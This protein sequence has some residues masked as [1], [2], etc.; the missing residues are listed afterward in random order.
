MKSAWKLVFVALCAL[1]LAQEGDDA[2]AAEAKEASKV[3]VLTAETFDDVIKGNALTLVKFF[4]PW[5]G[6][7]KEL[8]PEF[9]KAAAAAAAELE[10]VVLAEVDATEEREL[11]GK[12]DVEGYPTLLLFTPDGEYRTYSG[13]RTAEALL[14]YLRGKIGPVVRPLETPEELA[15]FVAL[16]TAAKCKFVAYTQPDS[17]LA[18][19]YEAAAQKE[20]DN[21]LFGRAK[22]TD[23]LVDKVVA[24]RDF[25]KEERELVFD[26]AEAT[27]EALARWFVVA[28]TPLAD[29]MTFQNQE[30]YKLL[31]TL[32]VM[33]RLD[34][35]YDPSGLRYVLN[36]LRAVAKDYRGR[37]FFATQ[38]RVYSERYEDM[39]F[40]PEQK[41]A[42]AVLDGDKAYRSDVTTLKKEELAAF[43]DAFLAG[44]V[45][46]FIKSAAAPR[47]M[48]Q[49]QVHDIVGTTFD[50]L[51][52]RTETDTFLLVHA[53]WCGHCKAVKPKWDELAAQRN[54]PNST[55]RIARIDGTANELAP[56]YDVTGYPTIFWVPAGK[57]TEPQRYVG[58][59]ELK[60][61]N[62]YIRKNASP[63][64]K[65][66]HLDPPARTKEIIIGVTVAAAVCVV[67]SIASFAKKPNKENKK[68]S[69]DNKEKPE[70]AEAPKASKGSS[71]SKP[72]AKKM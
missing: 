60:A 44:Q 65:T 66:Y 51:V 18:A 70:S 33:T 7:C 58:E 54:V 27:A 9:E 45:P 26:G 14:D 11:A 13:E 35:Q 41:F 47:A 6:H 52:L 15:K 48:R 1:A 38:D 63:D 19:A 62:R 28:S 43:A 61:F 69:K 30:R 56:M 32:V 42:V 25:E 37:L 55:V 36:R 20:S 22:P 50:E 2:A 23:K 59:R 31:P 12:Y 40:P 16:E 71:G 17:A 8:A 72:K 24:V 34:P 3:V 5:C 4:A 68:P 21:Y 10:K 39:Q 29:M 67:V 46:R 64:S 53:P 57:G 49:G